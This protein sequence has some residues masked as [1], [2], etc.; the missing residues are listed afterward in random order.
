MDITIV[1]SATTND[2]GRA[3]LDA[4]GFPFQRGDEQQSLTP[5]KPKRRGPAFTGKKKK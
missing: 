2:Q 4:F 5:K 3:L 1:T